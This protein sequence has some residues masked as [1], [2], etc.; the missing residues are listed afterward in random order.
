MDGDELLGRSAEA[1]ELIPAA[2]SIW[3]ALVS[4][5]GCTLKVDWVFIAKLHPSA[6]TKLRTLAALHR[7]HLVEDFEYQLGIPLDDPLMPNTG[8]YVSDAPKHLQNPWPKRV[9]A[10]AVGYIKLIGSLGQTRGM[11]AIA[12]GQALESAEL[13]EAILRIYAFKAVVELER[14][15]ADERFY[16]QMLDTLKHSMP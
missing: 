14:E 11:L 4:H 3:N 16:S 5:L 10:E 13:I 12:H 1:L 8:V 7:G 15:L 9:K 2:A 6:E